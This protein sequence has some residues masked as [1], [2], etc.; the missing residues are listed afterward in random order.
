M[1]RAIKD[2]GSLLAIYRG[3]TIIVIAA[4]VF[5]LFNMSTAIT[6]VIG[7]L[8]LVEFRLKSIESHHRGSML[9]LTYDEE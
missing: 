2:N 5:G 4:G 6:R 7:Q 1:L 9:G 3:V 8:E